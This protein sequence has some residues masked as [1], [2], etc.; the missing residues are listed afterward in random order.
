MFAVNCCAVDAAIVTELG[1]IEMAETV[2]LAL[3]AIDVSA[4]LVAVT[5]CA[6]IDAGTLYVPVEEI[7]PAEEFPP[8]TPSTDQVTAV[9]ENPCT[10]AVNCSVPEGPTKTEDGVTVVDPTATVAC[11]VTLGTEATAAVTVCAPAAIGAVYNPEAVIL[12]TV[13]YPPPTP[14]TDQFTELL[15]AFCTVALN[16]V[17]PPSAR[18]T[19]V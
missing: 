1:V 5:V 16:C 14:S 15:A 10:V 11:A 8:T 4:E 12:P 13:E 19:E 9:F 18:L 7:V 2:T 6:P 3:A 17:V